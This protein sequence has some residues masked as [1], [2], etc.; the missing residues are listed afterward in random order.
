MRATQT[1]LHELITVTAGRERFAQ[2]ALGVR[3]TS[4]FG[5]DERRVPPVRESLRVSLAAP[6]NRAETATRRRDL[7]LPAG[8]TARKFTRNLEVI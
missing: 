5:L 6:G 2:R 7:P 8:S 3:S 1:L 4:L